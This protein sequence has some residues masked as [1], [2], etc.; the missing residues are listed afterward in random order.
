MRPPL[1][2]PPCALRQSKDEA[3]AATYKVAAAKST[4]ASAQVS[5]SEVPQM[6]T[7]VSGM[8][9]VE[10]APTFLSIRLEVQTQTKMKT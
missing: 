5:S 8:G 7:Q 4:E 3:A 6:V 10:K 1:P 2:N 9:S